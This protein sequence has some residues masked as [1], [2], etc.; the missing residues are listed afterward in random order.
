MN[1]LANRIARITGDIAL[2][3]PATARVFV[4]VGARATLPEFEHN[5]LDAAVC[6]LGVDRADA[7]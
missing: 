3:G 4:A 1:R 5:T 2:T 7:G 6:A